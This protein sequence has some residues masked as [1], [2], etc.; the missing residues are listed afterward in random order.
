MN[1]L[2]H[3]VDLICMSRVIDYIYT[4]KSRIMHHGAMTIR[5]LNTVV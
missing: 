3:L 5:P 1:L 2:I 4:L